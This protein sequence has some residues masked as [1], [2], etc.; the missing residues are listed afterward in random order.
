MPGEV[1]KEPHP[2]K[3]ASQYQGAGSA[4]VISQRRSRAR[5]RILIAIA[6]VINVA[7]VIGTVAGVLVHKEK[8][9]VVPRLGLLL[10]FSNSIAAIS[11]L[12]L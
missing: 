3:G 10:L 7:V 11:T 2:E 9:Y 5:W 1:P 4:P 8:A 6:V 12:W